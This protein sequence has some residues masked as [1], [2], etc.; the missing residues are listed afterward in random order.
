MTH[1]FKM[2]VLQGNL[3]YTEAPNHFVDREYFVITYETDPQALSR[4][5]PP[6]MVAP[7]PIVKYEFMHMPD[8]TGFGRFSESGQVIPVTYEGVSGTY[9]HA[10]YLDRHPPIAGGRE[11]WGFPKTLGTPHLEVDGDYLLGTLDYG[12][13]RVAT[14]TMPWKPTRLDCQAVQKSLGEPCFLVKNIPH[15][16]G[17]PAICQL[18]QYVMT[19]IHVKGAWS[20]PATLELHPHVM[21]R[22]SE[23]PVK[24][25]LSGSHFIADLTLPYGEVLVDYLKG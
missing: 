5:L 9:V 25:V 8:A 10:M 4:I 13:V 24:N 17:S 1:P 3:G 16:D 11:I 7:D 20:G 19:D 18:V 2:P 22:V 15:V 23:L 6:G 14:G 12:K 21:A